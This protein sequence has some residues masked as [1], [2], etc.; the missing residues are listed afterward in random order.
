VLKG[1]KEFIMRGNVV[2]LAIAV[3]IGSAFTAVVTA[4]ASYILDP[5]IAAIAGKQDFSSLTFTINHSRFQY[6][7]LVNAL[8]AFLMDA[9]AVYFFVVYPMNKMAER[10]ARKLATPAAPVVPPDVALLTEIRDL[11][12]ASRGDGSAEARPGAPTGP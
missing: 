6:G 3:V 4:F 12:A 9:L 8:V 2:D 10:R 11:L 5:L 1:F 7:L